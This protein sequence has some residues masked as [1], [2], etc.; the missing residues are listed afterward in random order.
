MNK[1]E[2]AAYHLKTQA[3]EIAE[4]SSLQEAFE[5]NLA[6]MRLAVLPKVYPGGL[7]SELMCE[8]MEV[9]QGDAVL[10]LCTGTGVIALKAALMGASSV[11]GVDLNPAAVKNANLNKDKLGL[12]Q[13]E[14]REGSL[15]EPV[16]NRQFDV[17]TINPPYTNKKPINKTEICFWDEGNNTTITFFREFRN[18]LKPNGRAYF[19][20]AD[21]GDMAFLEALAKQHDV[22]LRLLGSK[23]TP[24]GLATFLA[25]AVIYE[26]RLS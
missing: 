3:K 12:R 26:A 18:Y 8:V 6:G 16:N 14:I 4:M 25:Y 21:F 1:Q 13:V 22:T 11:V 10:D 15:F 17:I 9:T 24:S 19:A 2:L 20:W 5:V 7:D 23:K